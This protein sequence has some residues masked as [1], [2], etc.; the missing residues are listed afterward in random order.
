MITK[1]AS[2]G[3]KLY[4]H[5]VLVKQKRTLAQA[6]IDEPNVSYVYEPT[7][8]RTVTIHKKKCVV[9]HKNY[10]QRGFLAVSFQ[11]TSYL[12]KKSIKNTMQQRARKFHYI[13]LKN[14]TVVH[15]NFLKEH[16]TQL[17]I[18]GN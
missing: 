6:L 10:E 3:D 14:T 18:S 4:F 12:M 1:R 13:T 17:D 11:F 15:T 9:K 16:K 8:G 7:K 5:F 2:L